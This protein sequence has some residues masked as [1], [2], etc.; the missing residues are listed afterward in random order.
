MAINKLEDVAKMHSRCLPFGRKLYGCLHS[1]AEKSAKLLYEILLF[2]ENGYS[3]RRRKRGYRLH[4]RP[5]AVLAAAQCVGGG[6]FYMAFGDCI[7]DVPPQWYKLRTFENC[8]R[9]P[10]LCLGEDLA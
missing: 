10:G 4:A 6:E 1:Q 8:Q 7:S 5:S 2:W 3:R 9:W